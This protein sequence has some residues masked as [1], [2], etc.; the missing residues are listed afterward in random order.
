MKIVVWRSVSWLAVFLCLVAPARS[1]EIM[2]LAQVKQGMTGVGRTVFKGTAIEDFQVEIIGVLANTG[3]HRNMILAR[4]S[5]G[6]LEKTGVIMGMSGSPV[7]I[8]NRLIGAVSGAYSF[9][10]E[11]IAAITPIEEMISMT[12]PGKVA[13]KGTPASV[14]GI[15]QGLKKM[16][17][18]EELAAPLMEA[19]AGPSGASRG[20]RLPVAMSGF[21]LAATDAFSS[22]FRNCSLVPIAGGG[23]GQGAFQKAIDEGFKSIE[24]GAAVSVQLVR[25]DLDMSTLGTVTHVDGDRIYA[26]GHPLFNMGPTQLP[27]VRSEVLT[28]LPSLEASFK[29]SSNTDP[30]GALDQDRASAVAGRLGVKA[31]MIPINL[32][33]KT[34]LDTKEQYRFEIAPDKSLSP[35]L[36]YLTL[37]SAITSRER[38]MGQNT[39]R[40][41]AT[42]NLDSGTPVILSDMFSGDNTATSLSL[43]VATPVYFLLNN[44]FRAAMVNSIDVE[45][46]SEEAEKAARMDRVDFDS[47][48]HRPGRPVTM[49]IRLRG[50]LDESIVE[51]VSFDMP[52][53]AKPGDLYLYVGEAHTLDMLEAAELQGGGYF[54]QSYAQLV[55]AL[56][57]LRRN[58]RVYVRLFDRRPGLV[59]RGEDMS[60]LPPTAAAIMASRYNTQETRRVY[61][62]PLLDAELPTAHS[63]TG[64]RLLQIKVQEP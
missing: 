30:I 52:R 28:V 34:S 15:G 51:E 18:V 23:A 56:N 17:T 58:N 41:I 49:K 12:T 45:V 1:T 7:Y 48:I 53:S 16:M 24:P 46:V 44:P 57:H 59:L 10:K 25:G 6:P 39:L 40:M 43:L 9:S 3:P 36:T 55:R 5:G 27:M 38:T 35:L 20:V 50:P 21:S 32:Q 62:S 2:P 8:E 19:I 63:I 54:P 37:F 11:P 26:F 4:L 13:T 61:L 47:T 31:R 33:F 29:I 22:I 64:Y 42:I 60:D 14:S